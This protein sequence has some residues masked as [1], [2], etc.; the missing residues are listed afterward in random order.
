MKLFSF[1]D[2]EGEISLKRHKCVWP[3]QDIYELRKVEDMD[4]IAFTW[5][6]LLILK[7]Y[8]QE[9]YTSQIPPLSPY[10][11]EQPIT[12]KLRVMKW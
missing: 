10:S 7:K 12:D 1:E 6:E 2:G 11:M 3:D 8:I 9:L 5:V 4:S